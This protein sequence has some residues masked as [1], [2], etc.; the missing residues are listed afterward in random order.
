MIPTWR[1]RK[2]THY[3]SCSFWLKKYEYCPVCEF[4]SEMAPKDKKR[5]NF[6]PKKKLS[7]AIPWPNFPPQLLYFLGRQKNLLKNIYWSGFSKSWK[8][9]SKQCNPKN[10]KAAPWILLSSPENNS[11]AAPKNALSIPFLPGEYYWFSRRRSPEPFMYFKGCSH[12][13]IVTATE[14]I[15]ENYILHS[16][17]W[18][19]SYM[20]NWDPKIPFKFAILSS[21]PRDRDPNSGCCTVMVL[22]G[23][24][25]PAF[26]VS[27]IGGF[28]SASWIQP[29]SPI[30]DPFDSENKSTIFT[31]AIGFKGK[32]YA[33]SSQGALVVIEE[34]LDSD[35]E[36]RLTF[37]KNRAVPSGSSENFIEYLLES[38]GE[39]LLIFL[40]SRNSRKITDDVEVFR[41][42]FGRLSW[43]KMER[44]GEDRTLFLGT[45][46]CMSVNAKEVEGCKGNF[47]YFIDHQIN[48]WKEYDMETGGIQALLL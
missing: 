8:S 19:W 24:S 37:S 33:I 18:S 12:G 13:Q 5:K 10:G 44:L 47:V 46:C 40:I 11:P 9:P 4:S 25:S 38:K 16:P 2:N 27:K 35:S 28:S 26:L 42:D 21:N 43:V 20:P 3:F 45:K 36:I 17:F 30:V 29:K 14:I 41:L 39:I 23:I 32:F 1:P 22:T 7:D 48:G 15:T 6:S 31:N 34:E